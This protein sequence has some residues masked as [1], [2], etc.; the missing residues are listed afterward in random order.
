VTD[1]F[2]QTIPAIQSE[3]V[4]I[5]DNTGTFIRKFGSVG[6]GNGEFNGVIGVAVDKSDKIY[7]VD[8][9]NYRVQVFDKYGNYISQK[10]FEKIPQVV[11]VDDTGKI[12]VAL[13]TNV[14]VIHDSNWN[15]IDHFGYTGSNEF[16]FK[17]ITGMAFDAS[18]NLHVS[19]RANNA[20][21]IIGATPQTL[22]L[23]QCRAA[24]V[25]IQSVRHLKWNPG[26]SE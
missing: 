7:V 16:E 23:I 26:Y 4:K 21:K 19:E 3:L 8:S 1:S 5:F 13:E 24:Q 2:K 10:T 11:T 20:V 9:G 18:G 6:T 12:F 22:P 25:S 17:F 15:Y 14:I